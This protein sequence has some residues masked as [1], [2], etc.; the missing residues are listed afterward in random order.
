MSAT[1]RKGLRDMVTAIQRLATA[2][3]RGDYQPGRICEICSMGLALGE[4][5]P[6]GRN[7]TQQQWERVMATIAVG[8]AVAGIGWV[9]V[10]SPAVAHAQPPRI[11]PGNNFTCPNIAGLRDVQDPDDSN[12]YYVCASGQQQ[13]RKQCPPEA[14]LALNL[15]PPECL[16]PSRPY[17]R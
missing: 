11:P 3:K 2:L 13:D 17:V 8:A 9:T 16:S 4:W 1:T 5:R 6:S 10:V 14:R 12:A 7:Y 15:T